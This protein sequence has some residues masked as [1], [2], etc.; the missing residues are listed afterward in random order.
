MTLG[1]GSGE[2]LS[3]SRSRLDAGSSLPDLFG[4]SGMEPLAS[5]GLSPSTGPCLAANRG[6]IAIRIIRSAHELGLKAIAVYSHE[7]RLSMHRYKVISFIGFC[8]I[9]RMLWIP[10]LFCSQ[11]SLVSKKKA[12]IYAKG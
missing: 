1:L 10:S 3:E 4:R 5:P 12:L 11:G 7:D 2:A 8:S 9:D 6:E